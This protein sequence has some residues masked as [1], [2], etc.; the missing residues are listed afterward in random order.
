MRKRRRGHPPGLRPRQDISSTSRKNAVDSP[1]YGPARRRHP[2]RLLRG[3]A[4]NDRGSVLAVARAPA[5]AGRPWAQNAR[6][7][8]PGAR[9]DAAAPPARAARDRRRRARLLRP[10]VQSCASTSKHDKAK[11]YLDSVGT[12]A[13]SSQD[14]GTAVANALI[15]PGVKAD[16]L[17]GKLRNVAEQERQNVT[18]AE[19]PQPARL[20]ARPEPATGRGAAAARQR[21][22]GAR[23]HLRGEPALRRRR[24]RRPCSPSRPTGCSRATSSGTTSSGARH[25][26]DEEA[27]DQRHR[28]ARVAVRHEPRPDHGALD[29]AR[30]AAPARRLDERRNAHRDP[31]HEHR[32]DE[33]A[34]RA[35]RRCR[36]PTR[37]PSRRRPT[38]RSSSRSPTPATRRRSASR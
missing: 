13:Q 26:R 8:G 25:E 23:G 10:A 38:S 1:C 6:P 30:A 31:R 28:C 17:A 37:T 33:G 16:A 20:P 18:A 15:T 22:P 24:A 36:R 35:G 32:R 19:Q 21:R 2:I 4:G 12:I 34:A 29:G 5:P 7:A 9:P 11:H 14:D 27:G 3:G